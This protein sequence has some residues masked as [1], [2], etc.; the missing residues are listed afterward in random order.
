MPPLL[1]ITFSSTMSD[2]S[3]AARL[4]ARIHRR[5]ETVTEPIR[6]GSLEFSFTR[7]ADPDRVLDEVAMEEER[8]SRGIAQT[9][10]ASP[11][12]MPYWAELWESSLS[13]AEHV[14]EIS[15]NTLKSRRVLDLG[16]GM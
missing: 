15:G 8:R 1:E 11:L 13:V 10:R 4:L 3:P 6:I 2:S 14:A 12:H 5:F 16:C 7:I 9:A